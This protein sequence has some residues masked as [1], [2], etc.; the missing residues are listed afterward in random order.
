MNNTLELSDKERLR[1]ELW[2]LNMLNRETAAYLGV[3]ERTLYSYL[4]GDT[5][6]PKML[7][8]ALELR[9]QEKSK[10]TWEPT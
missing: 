7:W 9:R 3:T 10:M 5:R 2:E 8:L 1:E 4:A 6:I